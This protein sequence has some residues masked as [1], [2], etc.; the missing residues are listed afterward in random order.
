MAT[1]KPSS[2]SLPA[3]KKGWMRKQGRS[4]VIKN[5]KKRYFVLTGGVIN[6]YEE[7][8]KD[9]PYGDKLKVIDGMIDEWKDGI[10]GMME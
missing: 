1:N 8:S 10:D 4:G 7:E 9:H 3:I 2:S 5:W 6:Y